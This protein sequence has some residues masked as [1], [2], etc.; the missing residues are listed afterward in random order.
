MS[1]EVRNKSLEKLLHSYERY[2]S[3]QRGVEPPFACE[4]VFESH[5]EQY[6]L[7]KS[8]KISDADSNEFVFFAE[9]ETLDEKNFCELDEAAWNSGL[10]RVKPGPGHRNSD[11]TLI[12]IADSISK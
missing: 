8:A 10:A 3:I 9:L 4:A 12:I 11:V 2:Y 7:V 5:N 1:R 6:F